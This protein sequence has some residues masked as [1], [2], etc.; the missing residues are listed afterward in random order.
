M[1]PLQAARGGEPA[2]GNTCVDVHIG[3]DQSYGC[4]NQELRHT[5]E[6][7]SRAM[8]APDVRAGS[9]APATGTFNRTA[10]QERLGNAFGHSVVPQR[11][12]PPPPL[13][14]FRTP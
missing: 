11:P 12:A 3:A 4:L 13:P 8:I 1:L 6:S 9:P 14:L 7:A 2:A 5:A 10:T